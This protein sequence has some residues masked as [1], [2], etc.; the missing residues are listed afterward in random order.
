M[1]QTPKYDDKFS[2]MLIGD[3]NVGKTSIIN[4]YVND[5]FSDERRQTLGVD[6]FTQTKKMKKKKIL[7]K[8]WD[9]VGQEKYAMITKSHYK[10]AH[11]IFLLCSVDSKD[12]F[13]SLPKWLQGVK[14]NCDLSRVKLM[15]IIS[16][17][18][19]EERQLTKEQI[20]NFS[21]KNSLEYIEVSAKEN[22][23]I[24]EMF[25]KMIKDVYEMNYYRE[26]GFDLEE[27]AF[28]SGIK[29]GCC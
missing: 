22:I 3:E 4:R 6:N 27:G 8:I 14:D 11:G 15:L 10:I 7:I 5:T 1:N 19:I 25:D 18:D 21:N 26:K 23:N 20:I 28:S 13:K 9:T 24:D 2:L 16:K 12:S 17:C 29:K